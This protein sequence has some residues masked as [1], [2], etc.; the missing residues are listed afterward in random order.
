VLNGVADDAQIE[1][2]FAAVWASADVEEAAR[3][4]T[5]RRTPV[6]EGR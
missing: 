1:Q 3:A 4:R 6:F 5:E 2:S